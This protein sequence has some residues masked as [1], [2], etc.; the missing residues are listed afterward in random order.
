VG[1]RSLKS[2]DFVEKL[3]LKEAAEEDIYFAK[4]DLELIETLHEKQLTTLDIAPQ[5]VKRSA[6]Q[7][8]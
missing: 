2:S 6:W 7:S 4:R 1:A 3:R 5:D 8:E